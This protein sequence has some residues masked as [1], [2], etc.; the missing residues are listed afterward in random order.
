GRRG[1]WRRRWRRRRRGWRRWRRTHHG[2]ARGIAP[3]PGVA[4]RHHLK[5]AAGGGGIA[6]VVTPAL[7]VGVDDAAAAHGPGDRDPRRV[8]VRRKAHGHEILRL[9]LP[10]RNGAR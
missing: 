1:G 9:V 2:D 7:R 4:R 6:P 5:G 10:Q 8:A 3:V